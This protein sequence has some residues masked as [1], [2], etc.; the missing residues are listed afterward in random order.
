MQVN[1][2]VFSPKDTPQIPL[3]LKITGK[4]TEKD[5]EKEIKRLKFSPINFDGQKMFDFSYA[6]TNKVHSAYKKISF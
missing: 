5:D 3:T 4:N 6:I 2:R 1:V